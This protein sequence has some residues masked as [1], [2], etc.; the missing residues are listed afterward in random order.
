MCGGRPVPEALPRAAPCAGRPPDLGLRSAR[1]GQHRWLLSGGPGPPDGVADRLSAG[2]GGRPGVPRVPLTGGRPGR[3]GGSRLV[4]ALGRAYGSAGG[5][6]TGAAR[7][8]GGRL[9]VCGACPRQLSLTCRHGGRQGRSPSTGVHDGGELPAIERTGGR[10]PSAGG[11]LPPAPGT[12]ARLVAADGPAASA[13]STRNRWARTFRDSEP[14]A[15][16]PVPLRL[17]PWR[18][19]RPRP[20][21]ARTQQRDSAQGPRGPHVRPGRCTATGASGPSAPPRCSAGPTP[22][23]PH[24]FHRCVGHR[25]RPGHPRPRRRVAAAGG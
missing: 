10:A 17:Q 12:P 24:P 16:R 23:S 7:S 13:E 9:T 11:A 1:H 2:P 20:C 6:R 4:S 25:G 3:A 22:G 5:P 18:V 15:R 21:G 8:T 19:H 14:R